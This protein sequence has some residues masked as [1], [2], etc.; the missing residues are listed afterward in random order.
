MT[1]EEGIEDSIVKTS[2][3]F[4]VMSSCQE[5]RIIS[6]DGW[7]ARVDPSTGFS[8]TML[9]LSF[10]SNG[11][12]LKFINFCH[13]SI[14]I[15]ALYYNLH[16]SVIHTISDLTVFFKYLVTT[17]TAHIYVSYV[18]WPRWNQKIDPS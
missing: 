5:L 18:C 15:L 1:C 3:C 10:L 11:S 2:S 13:G 16:L 4:N 7:G 9:S 8:K 6:I 17:Y 12:Y 14:V